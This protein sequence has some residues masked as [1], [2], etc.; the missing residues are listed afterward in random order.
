MAPPGRVEVKAL[1]D[2]GFVATTSVGQ[3]GR[4][5]EQGSPQ[6]VTY[7]QVGQGRRDA[8]HEQ[9]ARLSLGQACEIGAKAVQQGVA[10]LRARLAIDGNAGAAEGID[11]PVDGSLGDLKFLSEF[12]GGHLPASLQEHEY[13]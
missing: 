4:Q 7:A 12:P 9:G 1:T 11:I 10:T 5:L 8:E 2:P 13:G 6:F 3:G